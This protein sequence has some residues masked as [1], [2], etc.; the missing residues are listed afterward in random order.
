VKGGVKTGKKN[1]NPSIIGFEKKRKDKPKRVTR[2]GGKSSEARNHGSR[3]GGKQ[4]SA[5]SQPWA[6][7][8]QKKKGQNA[9]KAFWPLGTEI[10][11]G[12]K[13]RGPRTVR[14]T[15]IRGLR[16]AKKNRLKER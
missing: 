10:G 11:G 13:R 6:S 9:K 15:K 5:P 14:R 7:N 8:C 2:G 1:E 16:E 3:R 4:R 12:E